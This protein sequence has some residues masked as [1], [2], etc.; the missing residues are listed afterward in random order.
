MLQRLAASCETTLVAI[1]ALPDVMISNPALKNSP[2]PPLP[3]Q[4]PPAPDATMPIGQF[5][6]KEQAAIA[7]IR[8]AKS[9][10][11]IPDGPLAPG[12]GPPE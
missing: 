12:T 6:P 7:A 11:T 4:T 5:G 10:V 1:G 3:P 2:V 9:P 8:D